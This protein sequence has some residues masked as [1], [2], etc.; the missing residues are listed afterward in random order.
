M[1]RGQTPRR[2]ESNKKVPHP[3]ESSAPAATQSR[4]ARSTHVSSCTL[5]TARGRGL[6]WQGS[7]LSSPSSFKRTSRVCAEWPGKPSTAYHSME[8]QVWKGQGS[9]EETPAAQGTDGGRDVTP[10]R[11]GQLTGDQRW[12]SG[13]GDL[14]VEMRT[15][16]VQRGPVLKEK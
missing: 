15:C 14:R 12:A 5:P 10:P 13:K 4:G 16:R 3:P 1:V 7:R 2:V 9:R 6:R 8:E 11:L